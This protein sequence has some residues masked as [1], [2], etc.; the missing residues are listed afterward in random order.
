MKK[1][2]I[3]SAPS[4]GGKTVVANYILKNFDNICFSISST[5]RNIREGEKEGTNYYFLNKSDFEQKIANNEFIEYEE[6]FGN[7]YGTLKSEVQKAFSQNKILLFDI[8]VKGAYSIKKYYPD[9]TVLIFLK[10]PSIEILKQRLIDRKTE[11]IE[12]IE[13]RIERAELE[14]KM[15]ENFDYV[16]TND[17]L[18]NTLKTVHNIVLTAISS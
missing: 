13:K 10:P 1:I 3:I 8:D 9:E 12:Q 7:Y 4:G 17:V 11:Q 6:I 18:E 2:I 5:T 14:I 15:S 16:I